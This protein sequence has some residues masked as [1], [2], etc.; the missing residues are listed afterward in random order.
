M[1]RPHY[2]AAYACAALMTI[3]YRDR[4]ASS[5]VDGIKQRNKRVLLTCF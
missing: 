3:R 4:S 2:D 5:A 1:H